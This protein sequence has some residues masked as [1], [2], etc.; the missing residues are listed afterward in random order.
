MAE[1]ILKDQ[2]RILPCA[3]YLQGEYGIKN[4]F[5]GV[6]AKLGG[7]G[8]EKVIEL[9]LNDKERAGLDNSANAVRELVDALGKL[10]I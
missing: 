3:V 4:L 8:L 2:G 7:K 9:K 5:I 1:A 6:L 10:D